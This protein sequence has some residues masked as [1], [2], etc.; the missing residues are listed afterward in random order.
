MSQI[1]PMTMNAWLRFDAIK[2]ALSMSHPE[3]VLEVGAGQGAIA[4]RMA[5]HFDYTG[6]EP[7]PTSFRSLASI[8]Q[9]LG[10]GTAI[11]GDIDSAPKTP[12]DLLCAFEVLEHIE[13]DGAE[14]R[15][16]RDCLRP[17]GHVLLS[18]PANQ[19]MFGPI[20]RMAGHQRRYSR[21]SMCRVLHAAGLEAVRITT[22]GAGLGHLINWISNVMAGLRMEP[23]GSHEE[24]SAESARL[25]QP[26]GA[27]SGGIRY[28]VALPFRLLQRP[29]A[30]TS[31][32]TGLVVLARRVETNQ[33]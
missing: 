9:R 7:D 13:D 19:N 32:G 23:L 25:W 26:R 1:P 15:K 33:P 30:R 14:L 8:L 3:R 16:W 21:D 11:L 12:F 22:F 10:K 4:A 31:F 20:D 27:L 17:G 6:V 2:Q 18:V 24:A 28:L 5:L 29:F